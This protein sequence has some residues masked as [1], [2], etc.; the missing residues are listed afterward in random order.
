MDVV[1]DAIRVPPSL[2]WTSDVIWQDIGQAVLVLVH[3][4]NTNFLDVGDWNTLNS[5]TSGRTIMVIYKAQ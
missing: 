3:D 1:E 4:E 2:G 5:P